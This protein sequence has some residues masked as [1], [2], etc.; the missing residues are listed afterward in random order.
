M[1][2]YKFERVQVK[3][4]PGLYSKAK[5]DYQEIIQ[6]NAEE[7][8]ELVQIFTPPTSF[9]GGTPFFEIIFSKDV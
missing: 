8:W 3:G 5:E 1:K 2:E 4:L 6:K 7:G 9:Y